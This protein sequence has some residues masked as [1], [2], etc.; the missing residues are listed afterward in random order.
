MQATRELKI[1]KLCGIYEFDDCGNKNEHNYKHEPVYI[2]IYEIL[3]NENKLF[4]ILPSK[5]YEL[6]KDKKC[7]F[8]LCNGEKRLHGTLI[9]KHEFQERDILLRNALFS[10]PLSCPCRICGTQYMFHSQVYLQNHKFSYLVLFD[11]N[12]EN[13]KNNISLV[14]S[15]K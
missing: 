2:N 4:Y 15:E 13:I 7:A 11:E 9:T 8:P 6:E 1:C 10:I 3:D 12:P 14:G 5:E